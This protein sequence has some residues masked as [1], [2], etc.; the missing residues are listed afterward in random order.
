MFTRPFSLLATVCVGAALTIAGC[1][2]A[3]SLTDMQADVRSE[4]LVMDL[5]LG[6]VLQF[7]MFQEKEGEAAQAVRARY[8]ETAVEAAKNL[9]DEYLGSL[10][11]EETMIGENN[12]RGIAIYAFPD[13]AAQAK[14]KADPNWDEYQK[15]RREGWD[16]LHVF[17]VTVPADM[18]LTFDPEKDYTFASAWVRPGSMPDYQRYLD[19]IEPNFDQIGARFLMKFK[20]VTLQSHSDPAA[21]PSQLTIVEWSNGPDLKGLQATE[22]YKGHFE[23]FRKAVSA[24]DFYWVK[25]QKP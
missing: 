1:A 9:G 19:A 5:K 2:A 3:P 4:S 20:E 6:Q 18:T 13:A 22:G 11:V 8:F 7:A 24:F 10:S 14:F 25:A 15:M 23:H 17:S 16:E 12:P 21:D